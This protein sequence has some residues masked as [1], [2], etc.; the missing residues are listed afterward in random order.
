M[1]AFDRIKI[2]DPAMKA[3]HEARWPLFRQL[4]QD[5]KLLMPV[6]VVLPGIAAYALDKSGALGDA[7]RLLIDI[8]YRIRQTN[9][10]RNLVYPFYLAE[11][12]T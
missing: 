3:Y 10:V 11:G 12:R 9:D 5:L 2:A 7:G 4:Y 6:I 8:T 1:S